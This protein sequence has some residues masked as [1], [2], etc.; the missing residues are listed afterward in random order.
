MPTKR[1]HV[2]SVLLLALALLLGAACSP[3]EAIHF[4]FGDAGWREAEAVRVVDCE[5]GGTWDPGAVSPTNDHGLFQINQR[6]HR[7]E[8]ERVT[9]Q[10][11]SAVYEPFWNARYARHLYDSTGGN[12]RHWTCQ[13]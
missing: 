11:W 13:P 7:A 8:F 2:R 4:W 6:W 3:R 9:G 10:P 5:T 1:L 12:W